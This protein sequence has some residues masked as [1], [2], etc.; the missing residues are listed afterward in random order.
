M[1]LEP[2]NDANLCMHWPH[3]SRDSCSL[4]AQ[5]AWPNPSFPQPAGNWL[6]CGVPLLVALH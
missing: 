4:M 3:I 6:T 2:S 1:P 5:L